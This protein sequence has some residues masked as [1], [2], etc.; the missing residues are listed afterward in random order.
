MKGQLDDFK[1]FGRV[2]CEVAEHVSPKGRRGRVSV[3]G[4]PAPFRG[5]V[6]ADPNP[7]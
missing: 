6:A 3:A 1:A 4:A 7:K 5:R 2:V